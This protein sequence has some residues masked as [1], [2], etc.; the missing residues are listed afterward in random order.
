MASR[1]VVGA[2]RLGRIV[3]SATVILIT[4]TGIGLIVS[5]DWAIQGSPSQP[6][7]ES[8]LYQAPAQPLPLPEG[9]SSRVVDPAS[10]APTLTAEQAIMVARKNPSQLVGGAP[11]AQFVTTTAQDPESPLNGFTGWVV[12]STDVPPF[13]SGPIAKPSIEVFATY[14]W[15]FVAGDG[16]VVAAT[17]NSYLTPESV[18]AIP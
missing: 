18:P 16:A 1:R 13:I 5:R 14:S 9:M 6:S 11:V 10:E 2:R 8:R 12:L 3:A 7:N 4:S 17:Q 15:V